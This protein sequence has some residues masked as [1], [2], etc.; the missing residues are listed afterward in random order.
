MMILFILGIILIMMLKPFEVYRTDNYGSESNA[1]VL[2]DYDHLDPPHLP[3]TSILLLV[4]TGQTNTD[5][6]RHV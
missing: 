6:D 2:N 1:A 5:S 4:I 3:H